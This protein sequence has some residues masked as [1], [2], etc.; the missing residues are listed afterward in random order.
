MKLSSYREASFR[1]WSCEK[2]QAN[3]FLAGVRIGVSYSAVSAARREVSADSAVGEA[4]ALINIEA[5]HAL[6]RCNNFLVER[7]LSEYSVAIGRCKSFLV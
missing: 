4:D 6:G 5:E 7:A 1:F 3:D 2:F